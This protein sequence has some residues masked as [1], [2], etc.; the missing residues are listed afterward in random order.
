V[1]TIKIKG[2][3]VEIEFWR[4]DV[5]SKS[6]VNDELDCTKAPTCVNIDD[7]DDVICNTH[8]LEMS[9]GARRRYVKIEDVPFKNPPRT[10]SEVA[11]N[12]EDDEDED[13]ELSDDDLY[14]VAPN[15]GSAD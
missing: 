14:E 6:C 5:T 10:A 12:G 4:E 7:V 3:E 13:Y 2:E 15:A 11:F 1:P 8:R 9:P